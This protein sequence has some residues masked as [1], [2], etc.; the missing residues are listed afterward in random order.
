METNQTNEQKITI[1]TYIKFDFVDR[2]KILF[3][4]VVV[5]NQTAYIPQEE[6]INMFNSIASVSYSETTKYFTTQDKPQFG[7]SPKQDIK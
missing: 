7:Y 3:G 4:K 5:V 1:T 6:P 2:L